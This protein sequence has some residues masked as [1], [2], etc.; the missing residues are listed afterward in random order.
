[1]NVIKIITSICLF[2]LVSACVHAPS[3]VTL[4]SV[5]LVDRSSFPSFKRLSKESQDLLGPVA[6]MVQ[7]KSNFDMNENTSD[8]TILKFCDDIY[9]EKLISIEANNK[10]KN[11]ALYTDNKSSYSNNLY[12]YFFFLGIKYFYSKGEFKFNDFETYDLKTD[13]RDVCFYVTILS[14]P[15][16][17]K[18]NIVRI[19]HSMIE[20]AFKNGVQPLQPQAEEKVS[21]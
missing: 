13:T 2:L 16:S 7:F 10:Q 12:E 18:S 11:E 20:A 19:P 17:A 5:T 3:D 15:F 6:L 21:E 8:Y 4:A 14:M 1:M 9:K